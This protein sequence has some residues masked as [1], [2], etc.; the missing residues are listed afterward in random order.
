MKNKGFLKSRWPFYLGARHLLWKLIKNVFSAI[1]A[2][3]DQKGKIVWVKDVCMQLLICLTAEGCLLRTLLCPMHLLQCRTQGGSD[4]APT[5]VWCYVNYQSVSS[6]SHASPL[7]SGAVIIC[8]YR[9]I[10]MHGNI[11]KTA[12]TDLHVVYWI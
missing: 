11:C 8:F 1:L 5:M 7:L 2:S 6:G 9:Y 3:C 4:V 10:N 12:C